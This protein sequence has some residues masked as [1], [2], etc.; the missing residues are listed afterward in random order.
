MNFT[1]LLI[2]IIDRIFWS[3]L[4]FF[5]ILSCSKDVATPPKVFPGLLAPVSP[6][7]ELNVLTSV[8]GNGKITDSQENIKSGR[9]VTITATPDVHYRLKEWRG[10]CGS[11]DKNNLSISLKVTDHCFI[12]AVFEVIPYVIIAE[13]YEGGS[14]S[15][16][17][18]LK[19]YNQKVSIVA[20]PQEGY[21]FGSWK[22]AEES[23]CPTLRDASN[24]IAEFYVIG[25]CSLIAIF[26]KSPRT[27]TTTFI[28]DS[29]EVIQTQEV[30]HGDQVDITASP[31]KHY[32]LKQWSGDCGDFS[33]DESTI[34]FT[35]IKDCDL[36]VVF[37]KIPYTVSVN[38]LEGGSVSETSE[39]I[40]TVGEKVTIEAK[41]DRGFRFVQWRPSEDSICS[42]VES[43]F[44]PIITLTVEGNCGFEALFEEVQYTIMATAKTGGVVSPEMI[45]AK[46]G[47]SIII[48]AESN[49]GYVFDQWSISGLGC[50][51]KLDNSVSTIEFI[52]EG[53]CQLEASFSLNT[54]SGLENSDIPS[55]PL[56]LDD[57]GITVKVKKELL[58]F[59]TSLT[60][61]EGWID[62]K[63]SRGRV[64]Y[65]IVDDD[66][67]R[68]L[69]DEGQNVENLCT[70][71]VED[72]S[73]LISEKPNFNQD[74]SSWD[75]SNVTT[76]QSMFY[77]ASSFNQDIGMWDVSNVT[78]M[79]SMFFGASSF[80]Q[81]VG[82]WNTSNVTTMRQMFRNAESFNQDIA[83]WDL[84][85]V[86]SMRSM[87]NNAQRFNQ[88]IGSWN[89]SN[90]RDMG[91]AFFDAE[92]FN[93][94]IGSWDVSNVTRMRSMFYNA[95]VF[96]QDIGSWS[97]GNVTDM[98]QMFS[99]AISFNIDIG[100]WNVGN[101]FTMYGMFQNATSFNQDISTWNVSSVAN[102]GFMF[103]QA[104]SFNQAIGS[105]DVSSATN[106]EAMFT[107]TLFN[108]DISSWDVSN[109]E[110]MEA[111]FN[112][113]RVFN[114]DIGSWDVSSV[115]NMKQMFSEA[116]LFN[117][118]IGSWDVSS[119]MDM[120]WLFKDASLFNQDISSWDVSNVI[121]MY[122]MF[123]N[124]N[125][126]RYDLSEWNV[127]NVVDCRLFTSSDTIFTPP[128]FII[129]CNSE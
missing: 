83:N 64:E 97:V 80:N 14:V 65:I 48:T 70:T 126:F 53:N 74:I 58:D 25:D 43:L 88:D 92:S 129:S 52:A 35:A 85:R 20:K 79:Q 62:Y 2:K 9:S 111:M 87:F 106:M 46:E 68:N 77:N 95:A 15:E 73:E 4:V 86:I 94:N 29:G 3:S 30:E 110:N 117:Q 108:Q 115:T 123:W 113:C 18:V 120:R 69:V 84:T 10:D 32:K 27:I 125:A 103:Y 91:W 13:T 28:T 50:P 114:Q 19:N 96:N 23:S 99:D 107:G 8:I 56:Y 122:S 21:V 82:N 72:M 121:N 59:A 47:E 5:L 75:V 42:I 31:E 37:E 60:E 34:S 119:V 7:I 57:N 26:L 100:S 102:F 104:I 89:V 41:P 39:L 24:P 55:N 1:F 66:T 116:I 22:T 109:V 11:F 101:V 16:S 127:K 45:L 49:I 90:V 17:R 54:D 40:K 71:F 61:R 78:N 51:Q 38:A 33:S 118:D 36:R 67:L 93:Q 112:G 12:V 128:K 105:W 63:D 81:D 6:P 76:M 124:A 98:R 44:D